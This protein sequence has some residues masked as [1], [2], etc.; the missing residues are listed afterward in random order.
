MSAN[1][2]IAATAAVSLAATAP[3]PLE[4]GGIFAIAAACLVAGIRIIQRKRNH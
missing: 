4:E 1:V 3:L 2:A